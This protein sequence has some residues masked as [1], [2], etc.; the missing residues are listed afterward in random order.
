VDGSK[1]EPK[2]KGVGEKNKKRV[3]VKIPAFQRSEK[4]TIT[5]YEKQGP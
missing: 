2:K 1:E 4:G 5:N 3:E